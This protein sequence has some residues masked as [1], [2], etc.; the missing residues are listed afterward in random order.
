M[1]VT[2]DNPKD[3]TWN[4][5]TITGRVI[6]CLDQTTEEGKPPM[7]GL[8]VGQT[9]KIL[10]RETGEKEEKIIS[11]Y[12]EFYREKDIRA[13]TALSKGDF[14]EI[15]GKL[16]TWQDPWDRHIGTKII[17]TSDNHLLHRTDTPSEMVE[18][19]TVTMV[20][21]VGTT[22]K[23]LKNGTCAAINLARNEKWPDKQTGEE[24][25]KTDWYSVVLFGKT[26]ATFVKEHLS[27]GTCIQVQGNFTYEKWSDKNNVEHTQARITTS[28]Q[29]QLKILEFRKPQE[30]SHTQGLER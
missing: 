23:I 5:A 25:E 9:H 15:T 19:S 16:S 11:H 30:I 22:P 26:G 24:R 2:I 27:K 14:V 1:K 4:E 20:G 13:A 21:N 29:D 28:R 10:N 12:V 8:L 17:V 6:E 7:V 18:R 3:L